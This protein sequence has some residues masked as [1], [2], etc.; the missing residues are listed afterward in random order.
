MVDTRF[1]VSIQILMTLASHNDELVNSEFLAKV[2]KTNATFV[3][4]LVS[5]L[6]EAE[7][8]QSFRGNGGGIKLAKSPTNISLKDVYLASTQEKSIV[9]VHKKPIVKNCSVSCCIENVLNEVVSGIDQATQSY[10]KQKKLSDL[11]EKV[12]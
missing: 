2:L 7:L 5:S 9:H 12:S 6:V 4:K 11:M 10:L 1:S 3:R 8:V